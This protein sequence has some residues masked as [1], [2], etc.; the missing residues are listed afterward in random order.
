MTDRYF[1]PIESRRDAIVPATIGRFPQIECSECGA[2]VWPMIE[3]QATCARLGC[4]LKRTQ[5]L[6]RE[7]AE[8]RRK[9]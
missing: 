9:P 3:T 5:R 7:R 8:R 2:V 6:R 4:Q 1:T